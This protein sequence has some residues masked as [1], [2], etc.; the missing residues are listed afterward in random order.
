MTNNK[1]EENS[2]NAWSVNEPVARSTKP[3]LTKTTMAKLI[4]AKAKM[5]LI[6]KHYLKVDQIKTGSKFKLPVRI[7]P[8]NETQTAQ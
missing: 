2:T 3:E 6:S 7:D 1:P 8:L 5:L 4:D